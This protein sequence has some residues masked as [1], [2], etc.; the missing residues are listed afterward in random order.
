MNLNDKINDIAAMLYGKSI[1]ECDTKELYNVCSKLAVMNVSKDWDATRNSEMKKCGYIS[2]EFLIG[3]LIYA[4]LYNAGL[5]EDVKKALKSNGIDINVFE[6]VEDA[7]LGNGGLGRLAA[8]FLE[9]AA[10][11]EVPLDGYGLRYHF[12]L[13]KQSFLNGFQNEEADDW[14]K[15]GDPFSVCRDSESQIVEFA[16]MKV[17]AVPYDMPVIGY[18]SKVVNTLRLW[19]A[20]PVESF[21]FKLFDD[22]K[23]VEK[24]I[25]NNKAYEITNVLYP[26]DNT[27]EGKILRLRQE[28]F[29]VSATMQD[30]LAKYKKK[31]YPFSEISEHQIFQLNDT[32]PVL[33][34]PEL[35][36]LL[37]LEGLSFEEAL[38]IARKTFNFTNHT[39]MGEALERW[40]SD[41]LYKYIPE[42][43]KVIVMLEESL[44]KEVKFDAK[45]YII[46][47]QEVHM[48][49]LAIYVSSRVNGVAKIHTDILKNDT[50]KKW[51]MLYPDK[52]VNVTN[53]VTP[54]RW[55]ALNNEALSKE[56]TKLIGNGWVKHLD[57]LDEIDSYAN[58]KAFKESFKKCRAKNKELLSDYIYKHEGIRIPTNFIFDIQIKRLHEYKRQLM[59]ALSIL[60]IYAG[61]KKG[62]ITNFKPTAFIFGAKSA[63]GYYMAK[64]IIKL[65]NTI[66]DLVNNDPEMDKLMKVVFVSNYNV[67]Y[68]ER[69]VCAAD[70]SEQISMA[71][72]EASGTGNM[73][74]M[75]NGTPTLGTLDGANVEIAQ[76]AGRENNYIFGLTVGEVNELKKNYNPRKYLEMD[77]LL[78][79]VVES[80]VDGSLDDNGSGAFKAIYHSLLD[81][82]R[83][84]YYLCLADFASYIEAKLLANN[85]YGTDKYYTMCIHNTAKSGK[86]SSDRSIN[87]YNERIWHLK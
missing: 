24:A 62:V 25:S 6:E 45:Y 4:N 23:G 49:N 17:L 75:I 54:R 31:G 33:A 73:K 44:R 18:D 64:C 43:Y 84:D 42:V 20:R 55:L 83:A 27:L 50:F 28:Y 14:L 13:F 2:A 52:F 1:K 86:F 65:I 77:P 11:V 76:E 12:G 34:I 71:G 26:N 8:C 10:T 37:I 59:N 19:E 78:N 70:F 39:I 53:G 5:L 69:L 3:R 80:L 60:Y 48:A 9:S 81:G 32:H 82:D 74:F 41:L 22:M 7:A 51:Y 72:M 29:M 15:W 85:E 47:N 66:A 61:L 63:P 40:N 38:V 68:A 87:D 21:D 36:R 16:D 46:N 79:E 30:F 56:I 35:I 57:K 58:N 67:S